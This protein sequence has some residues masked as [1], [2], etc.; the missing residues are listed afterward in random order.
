MLLRCLISDF[1][2]AIFSL[3][4]RKHYWSG[5]RERHND[6]GGWSSDTTYSREPESIF[7]ALWDQSEDG[8]ELKETNCGH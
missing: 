5:A 7:Y 6:R 1:D 3:S 8:G 2:G 4:G